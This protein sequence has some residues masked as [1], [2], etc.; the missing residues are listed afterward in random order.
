MS[1][2]EFNHLRHFCFRNLVGEDSADTHTMAM[3]LQHDLHG[4][5]APLVEESLEDMN[6][7]LHRRVVV[8]EQK[9]FVEARLLR[10][11]PRFRDDAGSGAV[12]DAVVLARLIAIAFFLAH[13][14][15]F[16]RAATLDE[17][18]LPLA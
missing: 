1:A 4:L 5:V 6:D 9:D 12:A 3:D 11:R 13:C 17:A 10:L 2:G 18:S 8:V 14:R 7:E 16:M 15:S